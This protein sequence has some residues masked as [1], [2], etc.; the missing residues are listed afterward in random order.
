M[1][2]VEN[3][4]DVADLVKKFNDIEL[5]RR[6]LNLENE[7]LDLARANRR[8]EERI[9]ALEHALKFKGTLTFTE[10]FY[11]L[12]EDTVPFCPNC[13]EK[14]QE[15][16]HVVHQWTDNEI[17]VTRRDCPNCKTEYRVTSSRQRTA[18]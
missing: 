7:V 12:Q 3:M 10:P 6:I 14:E 8:G 9:E 1:G 11:W 18:L 15:A 4:K 13:W 16:I 2:V 5:N 17:G